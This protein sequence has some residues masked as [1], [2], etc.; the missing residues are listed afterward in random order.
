MTGQI[1]QYLEQELASL[2]AQLSEARRD[3]EEAVA[4]FK[5]R[6]VEV[7][8]KKIREYRLNF[9]VDADGDGYPI[10]DALTPPDCSSITKGIEE[11]EYLVD[12]VA[13]AIESLPLFEGEKE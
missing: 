2:K 9:T 3:K 12:S 6:A 13:G 5:R 1:E 8:M 11:V 7:C 4:D 10:V